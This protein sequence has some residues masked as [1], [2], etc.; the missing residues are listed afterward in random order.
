MAE[1]IRGAYQ[2]PSLRI[3]MEFKNRE[4][5]VLIRAF[6]GPDELAS[7]S[8]P[9][10]EV[11]ISKRLSV[12]SYRYSKFNLPGQAIQ[13]LDEALTSVRQN[14]PVWLQIDR[15]AGLLAV[16]PW[17]RLLANVI[18]GPI[19]R[20]PNF[21][22]DPVYVEG[23]LALVICASAPSAKEFYSVYDY[24]CDLVE[25]VRESVPQGADI[26][27]FVDSI[28]YQGL[29]DRFQGVLNSSDDIKIHHPMAAEP[30]GR[31][32]SEIARAQRLRSPW[33]QWMAAELGG[34]AIDAVH[35]ICPGYFQANSG[36]LALARSPIDN[37]DLSWSHFIG[38]AELSTFL[39]DIGAWALALAAP[40]ENVWT[41]G[42]RL[43]ADEMAWTRPGPIMLYETHAHIEA[44]GRAYSFLF[45]EFG[46]PPPEKG[47]LMLYCH[48]RRLERYLVEP[49]AA[50]ELSTLRT[51]EPGHEWLAAARHFVTRK[52]GRE[53]KKLMQTSPEP[54]WARANK[55][56]MEQS[57]AD[58]SDQHGATARGAASGLAFLSQ[59]QEKYLE[60]K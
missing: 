43:L 13:P 31:G 36:A 39:D 6:H 19:L 23:R 53:E 14:E 25:L 58:I 34:Q 10:K 47:E 41:M 28:A 60:D 54:L 3:S 32:I 8:I 33:L 26:H 48:P 44:V 50:F 57:L 49:R 30:F 40:H 51:D 11:G 35:F 27:L 52:P 2:L 22:F 9:A 45:S 20:I 46:Q 17:E 59:L 37:E 5:Y 42:L 29:Q 15:S 1:T 12:R 56:I 18:H 24:T 55:L 16:V 4:P 21:L 38:A 7:V